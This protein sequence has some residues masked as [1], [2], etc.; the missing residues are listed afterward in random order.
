M[1]LLS[2]YLRMRGD[3]LRLYYTCAYHILHFLK[4]KQKKCLTIARMPILLSVF[5]FSFSATKYL[6]HRRASEKMD[7][8]HSTAT[9]QKNYSR[10]FLHWFTRGPIPGLVDEKRL[11]WALAALV[12][13]DPRIILMRIVNPDFSEA[14]AYPVS[15]MALPPRYSPLGHSYSKL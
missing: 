15:I 8:K 1:W 9:S 11:S 14:I 2:I 7:W 13:G 3:E 10:W 5:F 12:T 6:Y 4:G